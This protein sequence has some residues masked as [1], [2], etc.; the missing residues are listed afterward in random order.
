MLE[1]VRE[2]NIKKMMYRNDTIIIHLMDGRRIVFKG[3][4]AGS[5][6][7]M[8]RQETFCTNRGNI[9]SELHSV[10]TQDNICNLQVHHREM[11]IDR[12]LI[13]NHQLA[14]TRMKMG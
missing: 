8:E 2:L 10:K 4:I 11:K 12:N 1:M 9:Y 14:G 13:A 6:K 3:H 7:S 5:L